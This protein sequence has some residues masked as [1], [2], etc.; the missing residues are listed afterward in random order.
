[1]V[2]KKLLHVTSSLK[3][4][5]AETVLCDLIEGLG[6]REFEH[7]VIYFH[8]GPWEE[9]LRSLGVPLYHVRGFISLY[10]PLFFFR[11]FRMIKKLRPDLIHSLLWSA[12]VTSRVVAWLLSV[13][14]VCV[15]HNNID[16]DGRVR[17]LLDGMTRRFSSLLVAVSDE[18]A[19]S[20]R[21]TDWG[22]S[23]KT[24][25]VIIRNG[26]DAQATRQKGLEQ[27]VTRASLGLGED[28]FIVGSV[29]RFC[30]VK[31]YPLLLESFTMLSAS[32]SKVRLIL[33]GTGPDEQRLRDR[34]LALGIADKT[35]FIVD[36][37]AYGYFPLFDCF[38]QSSDKEG[39]SMALLEAMSNGVV[40]AVTN[41]G[42]V[43]SVLTHQKNG[44]VVKAGDAKILATVVGELAR[45]RERVARLG[46]AGQKTV[47][48]TFD[49]KHMVAAYR[50]MFISI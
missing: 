27:S 48:R 18:V 30:P 28:H 2:R 40:C 17:N 25:L 4:G 32:E 50:K 21:R 46:Q 1:M 19:Q 44:L 13:P 49:L 29:G 37:A 16:Q 26:I 31:N 39:I 9:R 10:D 22:V 3:I 8:G 45:D 11:L 5:G 34:A 36:Q 23:D 7:H 12:N 35:R 14:H 24:M 42:Q 6:N 41:I 33:V 15:Y 20:I 38:V 47:N 43:H